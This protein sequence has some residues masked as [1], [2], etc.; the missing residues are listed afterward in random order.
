[1]LGIPTGCRDGCLV[2]LL[3]GCEVG[4]VGCIELSAVPHIQEA[5]YLS[6]AT[7]CWKSLSSSI[8]R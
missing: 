8:R 5:V 6:Q 2:G 1:V 3:D 4:D 7:Q